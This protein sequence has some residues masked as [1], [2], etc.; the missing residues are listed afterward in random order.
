MDQPDIEENNRKRTAMEEVEEVAPSEFFVY[1]SEMKIADIPKESLTHLREGLQLIERGLFS[2][3]SS[4]RKVRT[5]SSV[6]KIECRS[7]E[8]LQFP[9][10]VSSIGKN[11]FLSCTALKQVQLTEALSLG[12]DAFSHCESLQKFVACSASMKLSFCNALI[13]LS[14]LRG[15][16]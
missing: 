5:P 4:L 7:I 9:P 6:I 1:N 3:C 2:A 16:K 8:T 10:T 15:F 12:K 14:Y 13:R 11:A